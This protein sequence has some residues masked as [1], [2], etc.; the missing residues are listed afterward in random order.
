MCAVFLTSREK[1]APPRD[2][3]P[4]RMLEIVEVVVVNALISNP[5]EIIPAMRSIACG[6]A[7]GTVATIGSVAFP[8]RGP[9]SMMLLLG[10]R[11][12]CQPRLQPASGIHII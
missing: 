5:H 3:H 2:D 9:A 1:I 6:G 4:S 7:P 8:K 10:A 12:E 11:Q